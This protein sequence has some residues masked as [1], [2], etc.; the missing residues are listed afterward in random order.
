M[1]AGTRRLQ[2]GSRKSIGRKTVTTGNHS[3]LLCY[4]VLN[5]VERFHVR[6]VQ[7][8]RLDAL[9]KRDLRDDERLETLYVYAIRRGFWVNNTADAPEL[10]CLAE[11]ALHDETQQ[12]PGKLFRGLIAQMSREFVT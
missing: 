9:M 2:S 7:A 3:P 6:D 5:K 10:F 11:K 4:R 12:T 1:P 8:P